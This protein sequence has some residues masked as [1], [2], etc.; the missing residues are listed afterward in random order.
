MKTFV[1]WILPVLLAAN[2]V[3]ML[4]APVPWFNAVPGVTET[5][6]YNPHFITDIGI[7]YLASAAGFA[8][9]AARRPGGTAAMIPAA[10][11][12]GGHMVFHFVAA[13]TGHHAGGDIVRDFV[14]VYVPALIAI[15]IV[16]RG[17]PRKE[18]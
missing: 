11:F 8:W 12:L 1:R 7:A 3:A 13:L 18:A 5:G 10:I 2:G 17:L 15:W 4:A 9:W 14:G 6:P 16:W